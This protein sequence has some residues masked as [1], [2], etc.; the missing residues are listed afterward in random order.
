M[1][2]DNITIERLPKNRIVCTVKFDEAEYAAAEGEA[3]KAIGQNVQIKGFRPGFAPADQVREKVS[4]DQL[5]E[6]SIRI[7]LRSSL[8]GLVTANDLKPVV[9]PK[10]EAVSK[11]PVTLKVTFIERPDV[12]V[13]NIDSLKIEKQEAK[14]DP[15]DVQR[16]IDSVLQE[17]RV[18][19]PVERA[20]KQ[21]DQVTIDF[22][23]TD[24]QNKE[25]EGMR[26]KE[27]PVTIG[28]NQLLPGFEEELVGLTK[29]QEKSFT[30]T[31][32]EK[33]AVKELVGK[34]ATFHVAVR[35]IEEVELPALTDEFAKDKL[36][37]QSVDAFKQ[38]VTDS[39]QQQEEQFLR[40][41]RERK[42]MDEIRNRTTADI[43]DELLEEE[44]RQLIQE[45]SSRLEQ[46]GVSIRDALE[47]E[48]RTPQQAEEGFKK[49][50]E[51]R[52][53]LR[54]GLAKIIEEK[55]IELTADELAN[56]FRDFLRTVAEDQK[57]DAQAEWDNHGPLYE[58]VRWRA[59]VEK[60]ITSLLS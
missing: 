27:Y 47:K 40:I 52:W 16:V 9:P 4:P 14:A 50:A 6:E 23:A 54:L 18:T 17:H 53:K 44:M 33:F 35:N 42:L 37:A 34:K 46:Q 30:L 13:K 24:E 57:K 12:K 11:L 19:R 36:R 5:F 8:P 3:L 31:M 60:T 49:Q 56:A 32:P 45:W 29:N 58:E 20:A 38:M 51:E 15:K 59:L 2:N 26:A 39:V 25:I 21:G 55:K 10:V 7:L 48:G 41:S 43:A 1:T 28:A 22:H